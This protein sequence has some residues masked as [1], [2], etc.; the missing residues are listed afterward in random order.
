MQTINAYSFGMDHTAETDTVETEITS[1]QK[2]EAL[3]E[4]WPRVAMGVFDS[5][6]Y[7][8]AVDI[9]NDKMSGA[10]SDPLSGYLIRGRALLAMSKFEQAA[11]EFHLALGRDPSSAMALKYLGDIRF[12]SGAEAVAFS[13]YQ[14]ALELNPHLSG[15][16]CELNGAVE[17]ALKAK[18]TG[19]AIGAIAEIVAIKPAV[20]PETLE[21]SKEVATPEIA[22]SEIETAEIEEIEIE[23]I[24]ERRETAPESEITNLPDLKPVAVQPEEPEEKQSDE[25]EKS[26]PA[27]SL[28]LR[29]APES[30][31]SSRPH[32]STGA[33]QVE[34]LSRYD[35]ILTSPEYRTGA[36]AELLMQQG[37]T[38]A[39]R[40]LYRDLA[41][42]D[43]RPELLEKL[44]QITKAPEPAK[45]E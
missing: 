29:K 43:P 16:Y 36:M 26:A 38:A 33:P 22:E 19:G 32:K 3:N 20:I 34:S 39:A 42:K 35:Q 14:R 6:A 18:M 17:K 21:S 5:G 37:H 13:Y 2:P 45:S 12:T 7:Q 23:E 41:L 25:T 8:R 40:S 24:A 15:V 9:C 1:D 31:V 11:E 27:Q 28:T 30:P 44:S 4:Y 10:K